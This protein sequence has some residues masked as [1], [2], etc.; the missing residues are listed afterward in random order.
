MTG[1]AGDL[2]LKEKLDRLP[3]SPGVYLM[4][5]AKGKTLYV[6]KATN[7]RSRVR[8]YFARTPDERA[9]IPS[10]MREVADLSWIVTATEKEALILESTLIKRHRPRYNIDFRDD[11][12]FVTIRIDARERFPRVSVVRRPPADGALYFG[13]HSSSSGVRETLRFV[14]S[15]F[16][17]RP[18]SDGFFRAHSE[19][20]CLQY[21]I[22]RCSGP[23]CGLVS[24]A[25]YARRVDD[26]VLFLRGRRGELTRRL[27]SEMLAASERED[28]ESAA[29]I[30]DR[31]AAIDRTIEKQSVASAD[32]GDVDAIALFREG[33]RAEV[34]ILFVREGKLSGAR[35]AAVT[36][37]FDDD[38]VLSTAIART[39]GLGGAFLPEEILLSSGVA[40]AAALEEWL[41]EKAGRGVRVHAPQR[42]ERRRVVL[43][44]L[45][46][47][48]ASFRARLSSEEQ[49]RN[50]LGSLRHKLGLAR[51]P[52]TIECFDISNLQGEHA[53]GSI[54]CFRDGE[55]HRDGY[56]R[57][58]IKTVSGADDFA[59]LGEVLARRLA[60]AAEG[61]DPLP[62]L[63]VI[64]GGKGQLSSALA[65]IDAASPAFRPDVVALAKARLRAR[66]RGARRR[67]WSDE[68]VFLPG[69][70][71]PIVLAQDSAEIHLLQRIRDEAHRFAIAFHRKTRTREGL[72]SLLDGVPGVGPARRRELLTRFGGLSGLRAATVEEIASVKGIGRDLA[73]KIRKTIGDEDARG[74]GPP[75]T[76][77]D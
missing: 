48:E 30:R 28:F 41:G 54:A 70:P 69:R 24:E 64:D 46:N 13:P 15:E 57:F 44:A 3:E 35:T 62:D 22:G 60:R 21:E 16:G 67:E 18:C 73:A 65:A 6:G 53:V 72:R 71:E 43:L 75:A 10:L 1:E 56:R 61:A 39:Y 45:A 20:P 29:R 66:G 63:I 12:S 7:L 27:E 76:A 40:A 77:K 55:R 26:A 5:G 74:G 34:A 68:R 4:L 32:L 37:A 47:A 33:E 8:S 31:L 19:R 36:G 14:R 58:R 25:D 50:V 52:G 51:H 2:P 9:L 11:K 42:G 38:E 49:R 17:L 59:M 23:C